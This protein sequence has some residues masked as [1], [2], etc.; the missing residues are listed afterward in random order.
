MLL[1]MYLNKSVKNVIY[2][3]GSEIQNLELI[4]VHNK[5]DVYTSHHKWT[6][7]LGSNLSRLKI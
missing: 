3:Q 7:V 1:N 5:K 6:I 2:S 4:G